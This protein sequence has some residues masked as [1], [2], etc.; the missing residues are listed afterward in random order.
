MSSNNKAESNVENTTMETEPDRAEG[1]GNKSQPSRCALPSAATQAEPGISEDD[2]TRTTPICNDEGEK[3]A[4]PCA[5][6]FQGDVVLEESKQS[7]TMTA[8]SFGKILAEKNQIEERSFKEDSPEVFDFFDILSKPQKK[9]KLSR[10]TKSKIT[11]SI[12]STTKGLEK[13]PKASQQLSARS[14]DSSQ[15]QDWCASDEPFDDDWLEFF[16][17]THEDQDPAFISR[18]NQRRDEAVRKKIATLDESDANIRGEIEKV[19]EDLLK[20][21]EAEMERGIESYR[22]RFRQEVCPLGRKISRTKSVE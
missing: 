8:T 7:N 1:E 2:S 14:L 15:E 12:S 9:K 6:N 11:I 18:Q 10:N 17:E 16:S 4:L 22:E 3:N 19:L 20:E 5:A 21:K 13:S